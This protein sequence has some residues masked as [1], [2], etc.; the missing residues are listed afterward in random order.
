MGFS[1]YGLR[2]WDRKL[3]TGNREWNEKHGWRQ[4][5]RNE[6]MI[7]QRSEKMNPLKKG[8]F[9]IRIQDSEVDHLPLKIILQCW[10]YSPLICNKSGQSALSYSHLG[11][12]SS[13]CTIMR[14]SRSLS[15]L[16]MSPDQRG[17]HM[18]LVWLGVIRMSWIIK[19]FKPCLL[20][21]I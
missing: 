19:D 9:Y 16:P 5:R 2:E 15:A 1:C 10:L 21:G 13:P 12:V 17:Y 11:L 7:W 8:Y 14:G 3:R 4:M 6:T 20:S 18:W